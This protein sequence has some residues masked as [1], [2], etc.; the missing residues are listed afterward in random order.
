MDQATDFKRTSNSP[1][2]GLLAGYANPA[3]PVS[4]RQHCRDGQRAGRILP[5]GRVSTPSD[6]GAVG[7]QPEWR[8]VVGA[9]ATAPG[10]G[11]SARACWTGGSDARRRIAE[12][13]FGEA[14]QSAGQPFEMRMRDIG[15]LSR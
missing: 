14:H 13:K 12:D 1:R 8:P 10:Q 5:T 7:F 4:S 3:S 11:P 6:R 9:I 15:T 2:A